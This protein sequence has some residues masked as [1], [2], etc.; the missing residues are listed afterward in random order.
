MSRRKIDGFFG[1][2]LFNETKLK[3]ILLCKHSSNDNQRG[4]YFKPFI[5]QLWVR[6]REPYLDPYNMV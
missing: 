2:R 5:I 4:E 6:V 1:L 3:G